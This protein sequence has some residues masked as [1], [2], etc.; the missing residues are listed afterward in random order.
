MRN[1]EYSADSDL[2]QIHLAD[3]AQTSQL[4]VVGFYQ[5]KAD[6]KH[7]PGLTAHAATG[8][9]TVLYIG[10]GPNMSRSYGFKEG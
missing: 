8:A 4:K 7:G 9:R 1:V 5:G 3:K 10:C 2:L 6:F